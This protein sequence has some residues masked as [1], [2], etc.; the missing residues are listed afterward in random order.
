MASEQGLPKRG[1]PIKEFLEAVAPWKTAQSPIHIATALQALEKCNASAYEH[2]EALRWIINVAAG[3]YDDPY[4][5]G[6]PDD[7]AYALGKQYVGR[8]IVKLL[9]VNTAALRRNDPSSDKGEPQS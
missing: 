7:T 3:T 5:P 1:K 4:R 8:Q 2:G 9:K 6:A